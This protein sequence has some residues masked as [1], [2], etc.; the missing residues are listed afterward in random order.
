MREGIGWEPNNWL[1]DAAMGDPII[2]CHLRKLLVTDG[3]PL[4]KILPPRLGR[5]SINLTEIF[6]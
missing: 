5:D 3:E 1:R 6:G 2:L 4:R